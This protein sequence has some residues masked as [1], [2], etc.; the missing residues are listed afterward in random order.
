VIGGAYH[1]PRRDCLPRRDTT[2]LSQRDRCYWPLGDGEHMY[3][4]GRQAVGHAAGEV[5]ALV[6][7][8]AFAQQCSDVTDTLIL[9][10]AG[11]L[12]S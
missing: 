11:T 10:R 2:L 9:R 4:R 8:D 6:Y 1:G 3:L 5:K 12:V 7:V